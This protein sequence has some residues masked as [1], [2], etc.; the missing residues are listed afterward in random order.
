M[1]LVNP[2]SLLDTESGSNTRCYLIQDMAPECCQ[3]RCAYGCSRK[4]ARFLSIMIASIQRKFW[5]QVSI[6]PKS[7]WY[8]VS[9]GIQAGQWSFRLIFIGDKICEKIS[10]LKS[11]STVCGVMFE[12]VIARSKQRVHALTPSE[13]VFQ[14][15]AA[16]YHGW[17]W[18]SH[19]AWHRRN[20]RVEVILILFRLAKIFGKQV[21][22][23]K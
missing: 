23:T 6:I 12:G 19:A 7:R 14:Y 21:G 17:P 11:H 4:P 5:I 20:Q 13:C 1:Y 18:R 9:V 22:S 16:D 8:W 10:L 15:I 2:F 3:A